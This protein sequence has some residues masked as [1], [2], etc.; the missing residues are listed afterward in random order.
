VKEA[1]RKLHNYELNYTYSSPNI[2]PVIKSRRMIWAEHVSSM[3]NRNG[4]YMVWWENL[5]ARDRL[6]VP[7]IVGRIILRWIFINRDG[8]MDWID[9]TQ[10][11]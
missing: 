2:I 6:E 5:R 10:D 1:W 4:T 8:G 11:R 3:G 7:G 9:V